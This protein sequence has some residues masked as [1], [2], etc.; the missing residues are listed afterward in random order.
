MNCDETPARRADPG[1]DGRGGARSGGAQ[2]RARTVRHLR[3]GATAASLSVASAVQRESHEGIR[4]TACTQ[5]ST[6]GWNVITERIVLRERG[7]GSDTD[8]TDEPSM[9]EI[10]LRPM[11]SNVY[12]QRARTTTVLHRDVGQRRMAQVTK[13]K[14]L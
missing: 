6:E 2:P 5:E 12:T 8:T 9:C 10:L 14:A 3:D 13:G 11:T 7:N 1:A 4:L